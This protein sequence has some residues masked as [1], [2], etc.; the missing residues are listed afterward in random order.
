MYCSSS[1]CSDCTTQKVVFR[2]DGCGILGKKG[3]LILRDG[4]GDP[5]LLI[6]RKGGIVEALNINRKWKG[7]AY[8]YEGAQTLV[9]S[10]K[11]PNSS[12]LV[13]NPIKIS[14]EPKGGGPRWDFQVKGYFP[15]RACSIVD[16]AGNIIAQ[17]GV[18]KEGGRDDENKQRSVSRNCETR[19]RSGFCFRSHRC[20]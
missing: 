17:V 9:F 4:D 5:L 1:Q 3:E 20:S 2:V 6:R 14:T 12:C 11:E 7:Y 10:L 19:N 18:K 15:D 13:N 8:D 16:S